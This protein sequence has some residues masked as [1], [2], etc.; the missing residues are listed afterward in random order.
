VVVPVIVVFPPIYT[1]E[2][3]P[4]PPDTT[5]EPVVVLVDSVV[6]ISND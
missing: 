5:K 6:L 3:I 1:F 4:T 2:L